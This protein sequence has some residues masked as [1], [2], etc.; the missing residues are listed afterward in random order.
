[1]GEGNFVH[2]GSSFG[3]GRARRFLLIGLLALNRL[4]GL[5]VLTDGPVSVTF[6]PG[7][8]PPILP[9]PGET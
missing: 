6:T 5:A 1:L 7:A 8:D 2:A 3:R 9:Y 4:T